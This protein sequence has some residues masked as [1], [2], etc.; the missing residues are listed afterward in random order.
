[1]NVALAVANADTMPAPVTAAHAEVP[2]CARSATTASI[3]LARCSVLRALERMG[4]C[5]C[6]VLGRWLVRGAAVRAV[7]IDGGWRL[8]LIAGGVG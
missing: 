7:D 4:R 2:L 6:G 3:V 5:V 8:G 1:V